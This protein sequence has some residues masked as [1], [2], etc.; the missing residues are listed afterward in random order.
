VQFLK[1]KTRGAQEVEVPHLERDNWMIRK[2][3]QQLQRRL[4]V[5]AISK[6]FPQQTDV[7]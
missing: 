2:K 4:H 3:K 6:Q 7:V 1:A 5:D